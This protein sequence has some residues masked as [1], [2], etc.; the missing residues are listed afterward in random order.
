VASAKGKRKA[1]MLVM[2]LDASTA[3]ELLR[4]LPEQLV[5]EIAAELSYLDKTGFT[6]EQAER[7]LA[8]EL[9]TL[10]T[11]DEA[12]GQGGFVEQILTGVLGREKLSQAIAQ[13]DQMVKRRDP[14][15]YVREAEVEDIAAVIEEES[16]QVAAMILAELPPRKSTALLPLLAEEVRLEAIQS[17]TE[18]QPV[19]ALTR[20]RVASEIQSRLEAMKAED[21]EAEPAAD[22]PVEAKPKKRRESEE[23]RRARQFRKVA[24]LLR[25]LEKEARDVLSKG[26]AEKNAEAGEAVNRSMV[27]WEDIPLIADRPVQEVIRGIGAKT[28]AVAMAGADEAVVEKLRS[29]MSERASAMVDE[30]SQL[31]SNPDEKEIEAAREEVLDMLRQMNAQGQVTF[32]DA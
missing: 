12:G 15:M 17:L 7:E 26:I 10:V 3:A 6:P 21:E 24:V 25:G 13:V 32:E 29:N 30:E 11:A 9:S 28:L 14:F 2:A 20:T 18:A 27:L 31:L 19:S 1:A 8:E 4:P 23:D 22:E 5:T 16:S